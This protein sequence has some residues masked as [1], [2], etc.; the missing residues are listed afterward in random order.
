MLVSLKSFDQLPEYYGRYI[1]NVIQSDVD[2]FYRDVRSTSVYEKWVSYDL[3]SKIAYAPGKW[4][5]IE[6]LQHV[7]DTERVFQYRALM[8]A[9]SESSAILSEFD[10]DE[11]ADKSKAN[12]RSFIDVLDEYISVR[13]STVRL[14][15]SFDESISLNAGLVN[16]SKFD[17]N[18]LGLMVVGHYLHH[19]KILEE[20][21]RPLI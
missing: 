2:D 19:L 1:T 11:F 9:R 16:E 14:F 15:K 12:S 10:E 17:L 8:I 5:V 13:D 20:R 21:Y 6:L 7:I 4:T 18:Q 3:I